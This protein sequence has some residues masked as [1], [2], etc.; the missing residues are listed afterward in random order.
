VPTILFPITNNNKLSMRHP[1]LQP[2]GTLQSG[3]LDKEK[4]SCTTTVFEI[5][6]YLRKLFTDTPHYLK[7]SPNC[8]KIESL[9]EEVLQHV[10]SYISLKDYLS[11][12]STCKK[13]LSSLYSDRQWSQIYYNRCNLS[14]TLVYTMDKAG[15]LRVYSVSGKWHWEQSRESFIR[16][17]ECNLFTRKAVSMESFLLEEISTLTML[18]YPLPFSGA[19][20]IIATGAKLLTTSDSITNVHKKMKFLKMIRYRL[21]RISRLARF[22]VGDDK[23]KQSISNISNNIPSTTL[24]F[25]SSILME[26][27]I[28]E[29]EMNQYVT[30]V[31]CINSKYTDADIDDDEDDE[32]NDVNYKS[33][34]N[35]DKYNSKNNDNN[36]DNEKLF[37]SWKIIKH[38]SEVYRFRNKE[39][40]ED[41]SLNIVV[42]N[43][44]ESSNKE[45]HFDDN[46]SYPGAILKSN[47]VRN[48]NK[49]KLLSDYNKISDNRST[50][51]IPINVCIYIIIIIIITIVIF[52]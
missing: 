44:N 38:E 42:S 43:M 16:S 19:T 18:S 6:K 24:L 41:F 21:R 5:I 31:F 4:W 51:L 48:S 35:I 29:A 49:E 20:S 39:N 52:I 14:N 22:L 37:Y 23:L 17:Y 10:T 15:P 7:E 30:H 26:G 9:S 34:N 47:L 28:T 13:F 3:I 36:V 46:L 27:L 25:L 50:P 2:D 12:S 11:L 32:N 45:L 1:L 40:L 33:N 8:S